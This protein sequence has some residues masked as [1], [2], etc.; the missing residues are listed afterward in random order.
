MKT[1]KALFWILSLS[2]VEK[3]SCSKVV[4]PSLGKK[5]PLAKGGSFR[6]T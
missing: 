4:H 1:T 5:G 6:C 3:F 2:G